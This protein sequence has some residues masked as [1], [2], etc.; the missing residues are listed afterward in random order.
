MSERTGV[1]MARCPE[2]DSRIALGTNPKQGQFI[3]CPECSEMLEVISLNPL[4][5]DYALGGEDWEELE[6]WEEEEE[7]AVLV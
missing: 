7:E 4:E 3:E 6:E 5:L 1:K 2:C